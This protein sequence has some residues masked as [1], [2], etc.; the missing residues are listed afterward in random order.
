MSIYQSRNGAKDAPLQRTSGGDIAVGEDFPM[1]C[2]T[3]LGQNPYVRMVKLPY[4]QKMCKISNA[5]Y[6][7]FRWKAGPQGRSKETVVCFAVAKDK[8]ICQACLNDMQYGLPV[9]VRDRLLAQAQEDNQI[10]PMSDVGQRYYYQQQAHESSEGGESNNMALEMQNLGPSQALDRFARARQAMEAK[11]KT[12]FRNLPKLC[13]FWLNGTCTR[14]LKKTCPYRPCCGSYAFP[15][16]AGSAREACARLVSQLKA[17]G[18]AEVMKTLDEEVKNAIRESMK[19]NREEA[20][21]RR[22]AGSDDLTDKYVGV[23]K[24]QQIALAPPLDYT[25]TTLWLGNVE[26][27]VSENDLREALYPYGMIQ[28][29]HIIRKAKC[30]FVE[31]MTRE[32]A[33]NAASQLYRALVIKGHAINVNWAKPKAQTEGGNGGGGSGMPSN[34]DGSIAML[35][36]PG[37]EAAP[38]NTY[39][40]PGLP[41]PLMRPPLPPPL[42]PST[43]SS[44]SS[45]SIQAE[46]EETNANGTGSKRGVDEISSNSSSSGGGGGGGGG[47]SELAGSSQ[48]K[49]KRGESKPAAA[50][51]P[52]M[53]PGR[54]GS[55]L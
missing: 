33:E 10:I 9:G 20:I 4:G 28:N 41:P 47:G 35:P 23:M 11:N 52:S 7:G 25:I 13:S 36:P 5:P 48:S 21:R 12:A 26:A 46:V 44:S 29:I 14:V 8:N 40:L 6:Q 16:I 17:N 31:F 18:P 45:S 1:L 43:S 22:V 24:S 53:D 51:Y 37:M 39:A 19:G 27:E 15:E 34:E 55:K 50:S 42:P 32:M 2:E 49:K 54:M 38:M 30:A 3:C